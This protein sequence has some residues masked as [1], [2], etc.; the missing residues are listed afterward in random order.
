MEVHDGAEVAG[1]DPGA[2]TDGR[3][4]HSDSY[5]FACFGGVQSL[6]QAVYLRFRSLTT[7]QNWSRDRLLPPLMLRRDLLSN[8]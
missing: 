5:E 2:D 4:C 6:L 3:V 7:P 8:A 1:F